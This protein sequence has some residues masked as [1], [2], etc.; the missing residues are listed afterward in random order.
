MIALLRVHGQLSWRL[1]N[2]AVEAFVTET[3]GHV[4][5]VHF[6]LGDRTVQPYH[7][8]PWAEEKADGLPPMLHALR[9]DFFCLPFGG[10]AEPFEG[11]T[12]PPHGE[13]A[14]TAWTLEGLDH[15]GDVTRLRLSLDTT[16]RPGRVVK[17][18]ELVNGHAAVYQRH[19]LFGMT[20]PMSFGHHGMLRFPEREGSGLVA[21][22]PI[23]WG[24]T[25]PMPVE[26]PAD[27]GYSI[28]ATGASFDALDA[29][30]T[31]TGVPADLT[32]YPAR[33]GFEDVV[34]LA[35]DPDLPL[36]W[37]ASTF[38][39]EGFV[40]FTLKNPRVLRQTLLWLSN[41]GRH[42]PPWNGRHVD[43][44]GLEEVTSYF[45][46]GLAESAASNPLSE[47]GIP[48]AA[49]LDGSPFE[50]AC[51]SAVA[52]VPEGFD[53]VVD[54]RPHEGEDAVTLTS[55]SGATVT[56][57]LRHAFIAR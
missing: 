6:R 48:T 8:A 23:V 17:E 51:I 40:W 56:V 29:V 9:G 39:E 2:G 37:T 52:D 55:R 30:P 12:H 57:P 47:A 32:R 44:L 15:E 41:G 34:M 21:T 24:Q 43:V 35:S 50:V 5:P 26:N 28:L 36:A 22:S 19:T 3:G 31:I 46:Y 14:N 27:R 53:H 11:E 20:G 38:P 7:V 18:I 16:V 1:A 25:A 49:T 4:G 13:T 10:N 45:Y 33:R 42:Y 54:V